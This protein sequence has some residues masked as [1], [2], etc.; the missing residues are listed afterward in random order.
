[1]LSLEE[2]V[3][4]KLRNDCPCCFDV[5]TAFPNFSW[6]GEVT[7]MHKADIAWRI[8]RQAGISETQAAKLV[9]LDT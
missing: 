5:V 9:E 3:V 7:A 2:A 8:H 1:M 6:G 4:E